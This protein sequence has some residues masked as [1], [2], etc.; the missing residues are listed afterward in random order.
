MR[1]IHDVRNMYFD[2]TAV[3]GRGGLEGSEAVMVMVIWLFVGAFENTLV[4]VGRAIDI[5]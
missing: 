2:T 5:S 4:G 3:A 1:A